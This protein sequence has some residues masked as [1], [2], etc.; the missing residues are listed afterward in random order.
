MAY[1]VKNQ[2]F[3][4]IAIA[5]LT[6]GLA[7]PRSHAVAGSSDCDRALSESNK[8]PGESD[9]VQVKKF[10]IKSSLLTSREVLV[11][12]P[13]GKAPK[14]GWPVVVYYQGSIFKSSFNWPEWSPMGGY[15]ESQTLR[16]LV[17]AGFAVVVPRATLNLAWVTN[18]SLFYEL[19]SD[20]YFLNNVFAAIRDKK[21]GPINSKKKFAAGMSSGGYNTSRMAV[22]F[23]G[24]FQALV[25]HSASYA[26]CLGALRCG[27]PEVLP[28]D[29]PPT[30]FIHGANDLIVPASTMA[31]YKKLLELSGVETAEHIVEGGGH[32]YFSSTPELVRAWF[33]RH[34]KSGTR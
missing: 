5:I 4:F 25:I 28:D 30:L 3:V 21:F 8:A 34:L 27:I 11:A 6:S 1:S 15:Y 10:R 14:N 23:P 7:G 31:P 33:T 24:E 18:A 17:A 20:Y 12:L 13:R 26:T 9:F 22:S 16:E 19:S 29:H 32:E 2:Y